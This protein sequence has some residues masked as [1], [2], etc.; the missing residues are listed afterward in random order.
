MTTYYLAA[1]LGR[2]KSIALRLATS[3]ATTSL[4]FL[5]FT[6]TV[7][8]AQSSDILNTD[9]PERYTVV[10]GDTLWDIAARFLREPWRWPEVWQSN[11]QVENPDLIYPGDVLVLSIVNGQPRLRS[12]R[13]EVVKLSPS[14]RYVDYVDAIPPVD[15]AAIQAYI[16]SP[17]VTDK[18]ELEEAAYLVDGFDNRLLI[19]KYDQF[20]ARGLSAADESGQEYRVFRPGRHFRDPGSGESLGHEAIHLG[21][22]R[23]LAQAV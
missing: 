3:L 11:P 1:C 5:Y 7:A 19:G 21:D 12:L 9:Y 22:A 14:P 15:P 13:R 20:Y 17:L 4:L 2:V 10:E 8:T 18:D 16:N 6:A 23:L